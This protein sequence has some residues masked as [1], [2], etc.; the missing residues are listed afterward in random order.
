[1]STR[2]PRYNLTKLGAA[3]VADCDETEEG[4]TSSP[5][6][7][8]KL[9]SYIR[10][11]TDVDLLLKGLGG[12]ADPQLIFH[13]MLEC[14]T[15]TERLRQCNLVREKSVVQRW[16]DNPRCFAEDF[17]TNECG[18]LHD[19]QYTM[20]ANTQ[21]VTGQVSP[22]LTMEKIIQTNLLAYA[23]VEAWKDLLEC[24]DPLRGETLTGL[25]NQYLT[26]PNM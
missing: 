24:P 20:L 18:N 7:V 25:I 1:M 19:G 13:I 9:P 15:N 3:A 12:N 26:Q 4:R 16:L 17:Q 2:Y 10:S 8:N 14:L 6:A 22:A 11:P 5:V 23:L 21:I